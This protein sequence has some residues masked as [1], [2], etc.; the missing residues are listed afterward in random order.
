MSASSIVLSKFC[1]CLTSTT[2][3]F[4]LFVASSFLPSEVTSKVSASSRIVF[5]SRSSRSKNTMGLFFSPEPARGA[6]VEHLALDG[7]Q[8]RVR[9]RFRRQHHGPR[10]EAIEIDVDVG[11]RGGLLRRF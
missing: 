2:A 11:R 9:A 3:Y 6:A 8:I 10:L 1:F 5:S 4:F 7:L